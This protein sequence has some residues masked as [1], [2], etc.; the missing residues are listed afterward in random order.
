ML[1]TS[2]AWAKSYANQI[3]ICG[4]GYVTFCEACI[5]QGLLENNKGLF[6]CF[7]EVSFI[8]SSARLQWLVISVPL[9]GDKGYMPVIKNCFIEAIYVDLKYHL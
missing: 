5:T 1:L 9:I 7:D 6:D 3:N 8:V 2:I 4:P